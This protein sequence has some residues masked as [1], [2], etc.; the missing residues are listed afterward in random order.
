NQVRFFHLRGDQVSVDVLSIPDGLSPEIRDIVN[1]V[2]LDSLIGRSNGEFFNNDL[3]IYHYPGSYALLESMK[4][5][6]RGAVVFYF[7]NVTPPEF[8]HDAAGRRLLQE[9]I[10]DIP[11]YVSHSDLVVADSEFNAEELVKSGACE[12]DRI[13]VLPLPVPDE[14]FL[15]TQ[16]SHDLIDQY[17]LTG[18]R[19][20][21]YVGR[22]AANKRIDLLVDCLKAVKQKLSNVKLLLVGDGASNEALRHEV[23]RAQSRAEELGL[24]DEV[25]FTGVVGSV[26]PYFGLADVYVSAS[27]HEGFG[28]PLV[29][30]M[31]CG[32]PVVATDITSHPW[33]LDQAGVLVEPNS[34]DALAKGVIDVLT[35]DRRYGEL[36]R[37]GLKRSRRFSLR[38]YYL[39]LNKII[40]DLMSCLP[41]NDYSAPLK[42]HNDKAVLPSTMASPEPSTLPMTMTGQESPSKEVSVNAE[43]VTLSVELSNL[44]AS[45]SILNRAFTTVSA[46]PVFGRFIHFLRRIVLSQFREQYVDP[47]FREQERFNLQVTS[48]IEKIAAQINTGKPMGSYQSLASDRPKDDA[49]PKSGPTSV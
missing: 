49:E 20:L 32:V 44:R 36:V 48:I 11:K 26:A 18:Q 40:S 45:S 31:A 3:Y 34:A 17:D 43:S 16:T 14:L 23:K 35:D 27:L 10:N 9:S 5:I 7:H 47:A 46:K 13:R 28:V 4:S 19:I 12:L 1:V 41:L 6:E 21:L 29:E 38:Q 33:V 22:M 15:P 8:W 37:L 2:T 39:D 24:R 42:V 30:A 25:I